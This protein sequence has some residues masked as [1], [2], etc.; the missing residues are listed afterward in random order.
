MTK[1]RQNKDYYESLELDKTSNPSQDDIKKAYRKLAMKYHPDKNSNDKTSEEKF[2]EIS[3]AY[4]ILSDETKKEYYDRFGTVDNNQHQRF[5]TQDIQDIF[6]HIYNGFHG[7]N[8]RSPPPDV[9]L[10][11]NT[12]IRT[13]LSGGETEIRFNRIIS[14]EKCFGKGFIASLSDET[15][16][17]CGGRG[18]IMGRIGNMLLNQTCPEC[19][20]EGLK[21]AICS[22]CSGEG[23]KAEKATVKV[24]IPKGFPAMGSLRI[25]D[26]GNIIYNK[27]TK[28]TGNVIININYSDRQDGVIYRNG[29]IYMTIF[30]PFN[31]ILAEEEIFINMLDLWKINL[32]LC[33]KNPS[34][35]E[36]EIVDSKILENKKIFIK[37]YPDMPKKNIS[38]EERDKIIKLITE[39][40]GETKELFKPYMGN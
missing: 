28:I 1:T 21:R 34:G 30:V 16:K 32:K 25:K 22:S 29:N 6:S 7:T 37:V 8:D 10:N 5:D 9:R 40:Y 2:K 31:S 26:A 39:V 20:G 15:C 13:I 17:K 33:S 18:F 36:Y 4:E 23:A 11:L 24:K 14:C 3:E 38:G 27:S 12:N 35:H 19:R